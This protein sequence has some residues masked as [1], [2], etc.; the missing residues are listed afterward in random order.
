[1]EHKKADNLEELIL[2]LKE[3]KSEGMGY[4]IIKDNI[5]IE[6]FR[7]H[8]NT[9]E[10]GWIYFKI[11]DIF[12]N[13]ENKTINFRDIKSIII[14]EF[15]KH[16]DEG[17]NKIKNTEVDFFIST[18]RFFNDTK[19]VQLDLCSKDKIFKRY[20]TDEEVYERLIKEVADYYEPF[21]KDLISLK[22]LLSILKDYPYTDLE[23][24]EHIDLFISKRDKKYH[25][26]FY[27]RLKSG[28]FGKIKFG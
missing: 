5:N 20:E 3:P 9:Y 27:E 19:G 23:I 17:L 18:Q 22:N 15:E 25:Q 16:I 24:K 14:S 28:H 26:Y 1:M 7:K 11:K 10:S 4:S 12:L 13:V 2:L 8:I 6:S 21:F